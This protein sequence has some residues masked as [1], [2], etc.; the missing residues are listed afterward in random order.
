MCQCREVARWHRD[1]AK[2]FLNTI[3]PGDAI[4][5]FRDSSPLS[6]KIEHNDVGIVR[7]NG[8]LGLCAYQ[9]PRRALEWKLVQSIYHLI[10]M[11]NCTAEQFSCHSGNGECVT[12]T[13]MCDGNLDCSD[14]SDEA[15]CSKL[16]YRGSFYACASFGSFVSYLLN[17]LTAKQRASPI[18]FP[19]RA[20]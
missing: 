19:T 13:W 14:S 8:G 10:G 15:E 2:L 1:R 12:L 17:T 4:R 6:T 5:G 3:D 16:M 9:A 11:K 7:A 18:Q 20:I